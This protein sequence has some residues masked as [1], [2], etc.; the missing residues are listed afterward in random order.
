MVDDSYTHLAE[1]NGYLR[2]SFRLRHTDEGGRRTPVTSDYRPNWSIGAEPNPD[3]QGGAPVVIEGDASIA[4]GE[5]ADV[6]LF[7]ISPE[8]FADVAPGTQLFAFEGRRVVGRAIV[9]D[10][11]EPITPPGSTA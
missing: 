11:V 5:T 4:P 7:P 9:T 8:F 10:V 1:R 6:R 3:A 2:A